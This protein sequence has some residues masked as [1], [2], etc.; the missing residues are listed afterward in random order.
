MVVL[1][2]DLTSDTILNHALEMIC[3]LSGEDY[4]L[5]KRQAED[6]LCSN[7]T[8]TGESPRK[9]QDQSMEHLIPIGQ[10]PEAGNKS[11]VAMKILELANKIVQLLTKEVPLRC[12][13]VAVYFSLE[14][15]DYL[16]LHNDEYSP[17]TEQ[18]DRT[19][20]SPEL[21]LHQAVEPECILHHIKEEPD[22]P[23]YSCADGTSECVPHSYANEKPNREPHVPLP[24]PEPMA[25]YNYS[26]LC[27][28]KPEP[29][30]QIG[31]DDVPQYLPLSDQSELH[32]NLE[33][34][35][36]EEMGE[37]SESQDY[38]DSDMNQSQRN[39]KREKS[40]A[41][42]K[43]QKPHSSEKMLPCEVCGKRFTNNSH[44]ARHFKVHTG[45][46]PFPCGVCGKM[47]ARKS[48]VADHQRIHTGERPY[49]CLECGRKFTNNSH[50][51][52][53]RVVHTGEKPF[54]CPE[55]G[56]GFT[57]NSSLIKHSGIHAEEKPHV[58]RECGKSYCQYANLVVHQRLHS[59]EKPYAC[60]HCGRGF[61]CKASMVRHQRTHTGEK[62]YSC[63]QCGKS[64]TDNS[65]L[66]KHKRVHVKELLGS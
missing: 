4:I 17:I 25:N 62:P 58:C 10:S 16:E 43:R 15:W 37:S 29:M 30:D 23:E 66:I 42:R 48:H 2:K 21:P 1:E 7:G 32:S 54:T 65:S 12:D 14:E 56:K 41:K 22:D 63:V 31:T 44:L 5:V 55:C 61:I 6:T 26:A 18:E 3:L 28:I 53:H 9:S 24:K 49:T 60:K 50:L 36:K 8:A 34:N 59:G 11:L 19:L 40:L 39:E 13:D 52:L 33:F 20:N 46:K 51:V 38:M 47:F 27:Y 57:R 45:E 35:I 64:F